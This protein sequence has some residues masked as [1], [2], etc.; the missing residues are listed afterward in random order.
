MVG[1]FDLAKLMTGFNLFKKVPPGKYR[2]FKGI[3][4]EC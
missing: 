3:D 4:R 2:I 1:I